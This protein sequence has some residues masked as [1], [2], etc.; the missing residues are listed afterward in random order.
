MPD[1]TLRLEI[2][3]LVYQASRVLRRVLDERAAQLGLTRQQWMIL[4]ALKRDEGCRQVDLANDL[5]LEPI[6]IARSI[7]RLEASG[8]VERRK[9]KDDRR[10]HRLHLLPAARP[11]IE[12][13]RKEAD[14]ILQDA[15]IGVSHPEVEALH[16]GLKALHAGLRDS[17]YHLETAGTDR[18]AAC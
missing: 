2:G 16:K 3:A 15:L 8:F 18:V 11:V 6:T 10:A 17:E 1:A 14:R 13:I 12:E 7:D 9:C 4:T 5:D